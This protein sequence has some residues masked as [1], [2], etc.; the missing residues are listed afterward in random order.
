[1]FERRAKQVPL[2]DWRRAG[3]NN[4][5]T[6]VPRSLS[7]QGEAIGPIVGY[8]RV[9]LCADCRDRLPIFGTAEPEIIDRI[10][11]VARGVRDLDQGCVQAFI[12]QELHCHPARARP[13]RV[14]RIGPRFAP[15][16]EAGRPRRGKA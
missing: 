15:G 7:V 12:D 2:T 11:Q 3:N 1:M 10:C 9:V 5:Y 4:D 14:G 6:G 8:K 16:R 13:S